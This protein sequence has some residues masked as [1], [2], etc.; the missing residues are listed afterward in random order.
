MSFGICW[1]FVDM[2][3]MAGSL[4]GASLPTTLRNEARR[5]LNG[6]LDHW[7]T[8]PAGVFPGSDP[9]LCPNCHIV[10]CS[11][12]TLVAFIQLLRD[13]AAWFVS[14]GTSTDATRYLLA[15]ADDIEGDAQAPTG[16]NDSGREP[17]P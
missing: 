15:L 12:G 14:Q 5:Y 9:S 17:Y 13:I 16:T 7:D 4:N 2:A 10:T 3:A 11:Y 8:S 6:G 1:E